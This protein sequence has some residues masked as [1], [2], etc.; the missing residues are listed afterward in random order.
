MKRVLVTGARGFIGRHTLPLLRNQGYEVFAV[1]SAKVPNDLNATFV[2]ADL[3]DRDSAAALIK[4]IRPTHLLHLAWITTHGAYWESAENLSWVAGSLALYQ[5]FAEH[6]GT[7][8]VT[9]GTCAEYDWGFGKCIEGVTPLNPASLYGHAKLALFHLQQAFFERRSIP[10]A[11]G[12]I[13]LCYGPYESRKRFVPSIITAL[14]R[15]CVAR[16]SAGDRLRDFL[17]VEDVAAALVHILDSDFVGDVNVTSGHSV[18]MADVAHVIANKLDGAMLLDVDNLPARDVDPPILYGDASK[19]FGE[20]G[21]QP[22]V[23]LDKGIDKT[24]AWWKQNL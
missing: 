21:W 13:F 6:G 22:R 15:G 18:R 3:R 24:V 7:R 12:R 2:R 23:S 14:L 19:L 10:S 4:V 9:A 8:A 17:Y 5:S 20:V 1:S 16:C 11:W